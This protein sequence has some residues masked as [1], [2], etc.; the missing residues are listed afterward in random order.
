[1]KKIVSFILMAVMCFS[2]IGTAFAAEMNFT[3][4][5]ESDWFYNDV[6]SA[7][8][9]GL[10]NGKSDTSYAPNDNLTYAEAIKLA[11]C[12]NQLYNEGVVT[13]TSGTPW[14]A[15]FVKHCT[16]NGIISKE[17]VYTDKVTRA[18]YM[19]IF[20]N[21]LPDDG[22]KAINN[23]PD[24]SIPDVPSSRAYAPAVY[25]L[26][27]AG[28]LTGVDE[29]HNCSPLANIKRSEVA[30]ILTRMMNEDKRVEFSMD[31]EETE[32]ETT[33]PESTE[34]ETEPDEKEPE[35]AEPETEPDEKEPETTE[36]E[37]EPDDVK[38]ELK[39]ENLTGAE[40]EILESET[41]V[42]QV[43]ATGGE[44]E[45]SYKWE[46][47]RNG[48]WKTVAFAGGDQY[49][50]VGGEGTDT[51]K[52][53]VSTKDSSADMKIRC[54]VTDEAG[55]SVTSAETHTIAV[56]VKEETE[57]LTIISQ[58][59]SGKATYGTGIVSLEVKVEGG[60]APY[61]Y[62]WYQEVTQT[63]GARKAK[64][65]VTMTD[66]GSKIVG[67]ET[68][69]LKR[70]HE[71]AGTYVYFCTITDAEGN[72]VSTKKIT[73]TCEEEASGGRGSIPTGKSQFME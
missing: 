40:L 72:Q 38:A 54:V 34:P 65:T 45:Y 69:I 46:Y 73:I 32:P 1:M 53:S 20:A 11:A 25:K 33:E 16:D 19:E 61:K 56:T 5:N 26:Y 57:P 17:Y 18:G 9:M 27:R 15:P 63:V 41:G 66:D 62:Q 6:K 42:V 67:S 2:M 22:L 50:F 55:N 59:E 21:A 31:S 39:V 24:D 29:A 70:V 43:K 36:P 4:V 8:E 12:M 30:A 23:V 48:E 13:L 10:V 35:T 49:T 28:I 52:L 14:Y 51:L 7:V 64:R 37:T 60:K 47:N 44:G 71:S 68:S 3:D 58:P